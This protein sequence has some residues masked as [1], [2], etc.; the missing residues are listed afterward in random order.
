MYISTSQEIHIIHLQ[1]TSPTD[2]YQ[3]LTGHLQ[4]VQKNHFFCILLCF[5]TDFPLDAKVAGQFIQCY[6]L[7]HGS[8][9]KRMGVC[10][11]TEQ[12]L[13]H[14]HA[15]N[16]HQL[17]ELFS[18]LEQ[19]LASHELHPLNEAD[20]IE[21][22][23]TDHD[24]Q[25]AHENLK[26][27][28]QLEE[29][30]AQISSRFVDIEDYSID[31]EI[32]KSLQKLGEHLDIQQCY[33]VR[34]SQDH[35]QGYHIDEWNNKGTEVFSPL[36][37]LLEQ[38]EEWLKNELNT[39]K[40]VF[41]P[42]CEE[43]SPTP[44]LDSE[45]RD[46]ILIPVFYKK[47]L[48]GFWGMVLPHQR[49]GW[50][51]SD[52]MIFSILGEVFTGAARRR[53]VMEK[54]KQAK[55]LA[56]KSNQAKSQFLANMSH[57][58]RTPMHAILG[59]SDLGVQHLDH[60]KTATDKLYKYF[61]NIKGSGERLLRLLN[62]LLDLSKLEAGKMSFKMEP[63]N[64]PEVTRQVLTDIQPLIDEKQLIINL[65]APDNPPGCLFDRD[66]MSQVI[67]NLISNAIKVSLPETNIWINIVEKSMENVLE[68][69]IRDE[70]PGIPEGELEA[71]FDKFV[72][73]SQTIAKGGGTGLGL[74]ISR[75]I[76]EAH[77]GKI[78]AQNAQE[79]GAVFIFRLPIH[80]SITL[81]M[82]Q[83]T[84]AY[85]DKF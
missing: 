33:F 30:L 49:K 13:S 9:A 11:L 53:Q 63:N 37:L 68:F 80:D 19:A 36:P 18:T 48:E 62:D 21:F 6:K 3:E 44:V 79:Q 5:Q 74:S 28:L 23:Y 42:Y 32:H 39:L 58:L 67:R 25:L 7:L 31:E 56:E 60:K 81:K 40:T 8:Y 51:P 71:V 83:A 12:S 65:E 29:L 41:L 66:R 22:S 2:W 38:N 43:N 72:Q 4:T 77:Q 20:R 75:E 46:L 69:M 15:M 61:N 26:K 47:Q 59:Y 52:F 50:D 73:S 57:E 85:E 35:K 76:L 10:G 54:L 45:L 14:L 78:W 70:G 1:T 64:L 16:I 34:W 55:E 82:Q 17:F 84:N 27:R 24:F